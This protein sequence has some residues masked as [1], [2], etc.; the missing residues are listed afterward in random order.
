MSAP[1]PQAGPKVLWPA[2]AGVLSGGLL[3]TGQ[4]LFWRTPET[5][6]RGA[7]VT[8]VH[9]YRDEGNQNL[10]EATALIL[11]GAGLLFLWFLAELSRRSDTRSKLVLAGGLV[12]TIGIMLA[13]VA[14][15]VF[16]ITANHSKD[17]LVIPGTALL[18]MVLLDVA[19]GATIAA[20]LG[21]SVLLFAVWRN[22]ALPSW[23]TWTGFVIA[24]L[25]LGGPFSAWGTPLLVGAW[26][27]LAGAVLIATGAGA[28][29]GA[30]TTTGT[31]PSAPPPTTNT[32]DTS[33]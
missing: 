18:S 1:T 20:M 30:G 15:N 5:D 21:A 23:L 10:S 29:I 25:C 17:F 16:A 8:L 2:I 4:L 13:G 19:Y 6:K 22:H 28:G 9:Y 14:G 11:L 31:R 27:L 7:L 3:I 24:I 32:T 26:T 12:F 33:P